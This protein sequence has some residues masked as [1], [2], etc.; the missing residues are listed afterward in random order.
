M[1]TWSCTLKG[2]LTPHPLACTKLLYAP[3][4]VLASAVE[5]KEHQHNLLKN[6]M[7]TQ[8]HLMHMN[9][10][11]KQCGALTLIA[12]HKTHMEIA[13]LRYTTYFFS[14]CDYCSTVKSLQ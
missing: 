7:S 5:K 13:L 4:K 6:W 9:V 3:Q 1:I 14:M 12:L 10:N 8:V 2:P 11:E